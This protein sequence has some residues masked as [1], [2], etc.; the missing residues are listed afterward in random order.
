MCES[1]VSTLR[2]CATDG[3]VAAW[4]EFERIFRSSM[5]AGVARALGLGGSRAD[6][7]LIGELLQEVYCRLLERDRWVLRCFRGR[8]DAEAHVYLKRIATSVTLDRLRYEQAAKRGA[9]LIS[10]EPAETVS[11]SVAACGPSP[12]QRLERRE[13]W[14]C[15]WRDCRRVLGTRSAARDLAIVQLAVFEGWSSREIAARFF[16]ALTVS[17]VDSV[18]HRARRR[19]A[20]HGIELPER[21][22]AARSLASPPRTRRGGSG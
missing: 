5:V 14:R 20:A 11:D 19:L 10:V 2:R 7:E 12:E 18:L 6:G 17:A 4:A 16:P 1:A 15:F 8:E 13:S 9:A 22:R 3:T 21:G